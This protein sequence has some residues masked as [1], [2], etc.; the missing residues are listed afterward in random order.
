MQHKGI[1]SRHQYTEKVL[2]RKHSGWISGCRLFHPM[3]AKAP[4]V[5]LC[6]LKIHSSQLDNILELCT[7]SRTFSFGGF[8]IGQNQ[9]TYWKEKE[10][11]RFR[12][13]LI[14]VTFLKKRRNLVFSSWVDF[15]PKITSRTFKVGWWQREG[16]NVRA[17]AT[18]L[19]GENS[20]RMEGVSNTPKG[21]IHKN[22]CLVV[23]IIKKINLFKYEYYKSAF[24]YG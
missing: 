2:H 1:F 17:I 16:E 6:A 23:I 11:L 4:L 18:P 7:L 24:S 3:C 22:P 20:Y 9:L 14:T 21:Y 10:K 8:S 15:L 5:W 19:K 12:P 13:H